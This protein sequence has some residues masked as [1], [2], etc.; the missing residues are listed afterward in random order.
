MTF[1]AARPVAAGPTGGPTGPRRL[2]AVLALT[3]TVGYGVLFY[4]FPVLLL[5]VAEDL[6][7]ST[8]AVTGAATLS[9][10]VG[11]AAAVPVGRWLDRHG[12]RALMTLGSVLGVAAVLAWS[13]V[14]TV[15]QLYLVFVV[16]GLAGAGSLYEAAFPVLIAATDPG[17]RD[18]AL[19]AVTIVAGF[20]SSVFL[21]LTGW[22]LAEHG[23]RT[24]LVVLAVVLAVT[25]IP[26]HALAVPARGTH[27]A[28]ADLRVGRST[29]DALRDLRFWW[30][31]VAFVAHAAAIS[32]VAVLLVSYL[33]LAGHP[34]TVAAT[35]SGLLGLLSVTGRIA[36]SGL[37]RRYGMTAVTAVVFAVQAAG[38]AALPHVGGSLAGAV[39]C[40]TA[41]GLGFGVATIARPAIVAD[42]YGTHRYATIAAAMAVPIALAKAGAPLAAAFLGTGRFLP[43]AAAACLVAA[44]GLWTSTRVAAHQPT[45]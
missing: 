35:I 4:T 17:R 3:Q 37:A 28:T 5:P 45:T 24:A 8:A 41:F 29:R 36:T 34:T 20:A 44:V 21:P 16:I 39:A 18:R 27:H 13:R 42:R 30:L 10:L 9:I 22:L 11:V 38:A 6:G 25:A 7:V 32:A 2:I 31:T 33:R 43:W 19:L 1:T 14:Q 26:G 12:G 40:V 15:S 23:W